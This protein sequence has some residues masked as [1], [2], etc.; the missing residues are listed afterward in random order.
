VQ[1][2]NKQGWGRVAGQALKTFEYGEGDSAATV[3]GVLRELTQAQLITT[4]QLEIARLES[5]TLKKPIEFCLVDLGFISEHALA[6]ASSKAKGVEHLSLKHAVLDPDLIKRIPQQIAEQHKIL[7]LEFD[8]GVLRLAVVDVY[9]VPAFDK[10][11]SL[12]TGIKEI[13]PVVVSESDLLEAIDR[14]Y[15]YEMSINGLLKEIESGR[16][17][18]SDVESYVSPTVRLVDAIILD[19]VKVGASDIHFE[20]E[21]AYMR[22]RYRIDGLLRQIRTLHSSYWPAMCV[23]VKVISNLNIAESRKP[24]SGRF[25]FNIGPREVDFRVASHPTVHG[26]N[27]VLRILDKSRSLLSLEQLG[28]S[29]QVSAQIKEA[30]QK[31]EGVFIFTGPTGCGKTT[32][33]YSILAHISSIHVNIMTLEE[34]VEYTLPLIRQ[35]DIKETFSFADGVRSI[36]R[37]DPDIILIGEIRDQ[38]TAHMALRAAMTGHQVFSTLHTNEAV[39]AIDRLEDLGLN[40]NLLASHVTTVIAQRLVRRLCPHCKVGEPVN[41]REAELLGCKKGTPIF[42][43]KGCSHC[44]HTGY[45]G[46]MA[47]AEVLTFTPALQDRIH[48]GMSL[49][50]IKEQAIAEGMV[51]LSQDARLRVLSGDTSTDEMLRTIDLK[52]EG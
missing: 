1:N 16:G 19:A 50:S 31:P 12:L 47:I 4:D 32:S 23:R 46:R 38:P 15:G 27:L 3:R 30:L 6:E 41:S 36:L 40:R 11:R 2:E 20:P 26:E 52:G 18:V 51:P 24:Q 21:G 42:K 45:R 25:S 5:K 17:V 43:A 14:Y 48:K 37:Q 34:P 9:N 35:S 13:Q 44:H 49:Q 28:Y 10:V 33:L 39:S 7:A 8:D 22:V 29:N